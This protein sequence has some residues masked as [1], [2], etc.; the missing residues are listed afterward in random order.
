MRKGPRRPRQGRALPSSCLRNGGSVNN[1][2][3]PGSRGR[4]AAPVGTAPKDELP[5]PA[6]LPP[7]LPRTR[8]PSCRAVHRKRLAGPTLRTEPSASAPRATGR[9][10]LQSGRRTASPHSCALAARGLAVREDVTVHSALG[11]AAAGAAVTE[12]PPGPATQL[13]RHQTG[14]RTSLPTGTRRQHRTPR[15]PDSR[16]FLQGDRPGAGTSRPGGG[17]APARQRPAAQDT[18]GGRAVQGTATV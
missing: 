1:V 6:H 12:K 8:A 15:R 4:R 18:T 2:S 5:G 3:P 9:P 14:L 11:G 7:K 16:C 13:R 10:P 17:A